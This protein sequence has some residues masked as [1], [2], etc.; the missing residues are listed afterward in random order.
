MII[1]DR[2]FI[3]PNCNREL[4][5]LPGTYYV[6]VCLCNNKCYTIHPND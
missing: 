4:H 3:C 1:I 5:V 2:V 6:Y